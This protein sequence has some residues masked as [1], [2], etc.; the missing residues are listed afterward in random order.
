V[1]AL[2][3]QSDRDAVIVDRAAFVAGDGRETHLLFDIAPKTCEYTR[4][5]RRGIATHA[6]EGLLG[7][8]TRRW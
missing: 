6:F 8:L 7:A 3:Q 1:R 2:A 5:C 4:Q